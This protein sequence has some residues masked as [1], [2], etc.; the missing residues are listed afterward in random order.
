MYHQIEQYK[1]LLETLSNNH[2]LIFLGLSLLTTVSFMEYA[3]S[4][5]GL[6]IHHMVDTN[7]IVGELI[8][9]DLWGILDTSL[10]TFA[11]L[12][13]IYLIKKEVI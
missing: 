8:S 3:T 7:P 9:L 11:V 1:R 2:R 12:S 5:A 13:G 10:I 6:I 4:N